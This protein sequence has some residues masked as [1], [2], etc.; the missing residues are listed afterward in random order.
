MGAFNVFN[1]HPTYFEILDLLVITW[2]EGDIGLVIT[3]V[4][5]VL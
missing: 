3:L 5:E 1:K 2:E 4:P